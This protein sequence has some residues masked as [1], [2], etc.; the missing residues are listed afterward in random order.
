MLVIVN[1][2]SKSED[3]MNSLT[4]RQRDFLQAAID[5]VSREGFSRLTIRNIAAAVGVTEPSVYRHFPNKLSLMTAMLEDLQ[6]AIMPHFLTLRNGG[7][8]SE[9]RFAQF[10]HNLFS[11]LKQRPA[12]A[13]FLFSEEIFHNEP[14]LR[15]KLK[16]VMNEN[17]SVLTEAFESMQT[18]Q[19]CRGDIRPQEMAFLTLASI[20][21][22][23]TRWHLSEGTLRLKDLEDNLA[24][25]LNTLLEIR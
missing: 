2:Y 8:E 9:Q 4:D 3:R 5:I 13:P 11:E 22:A 17:M 16:Q 21:L 12:S 18:E 20:R 7:G 19:V 6:S 1:Y 23:V 10:L 24:A 25:T 15:N 14:Q